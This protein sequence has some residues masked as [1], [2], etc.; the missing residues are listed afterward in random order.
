[1][2][3]AN[4]TDRLPTEILPADRLLT[5]A[6]FQKL[7]DVP[8]EVE[9]FAN[10][11]NRHTRR[12]YENAVKDFMRFAGIF[13]PE[14]FRTVTR[15]HLIAWRDELRRRG[16]GGSTIRHRLAALASLFEYLCERNA[17]T[18]N[19]VKGVERP[20]SE[21]GEGKTPALDDHQARKLLAA[22]EADT[23]K[24]KRDRAI[25]STLLYHALRREELC[26]LTVKDAQHA[27]KGVPHL[28]VSGKGGKT[29]HLPLHGV[30][31]DLIEEYLQ[32]CGHGGNDK[33]ALFR[34]LRNAHGGGREKAI[35]PDGIYKM[36]RLYSAVL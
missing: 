33:G 31:R 2:N 13:R 36:V 5:A 21:S 24:S 1:M 22:P 23:I 9:W 18:Y 7:A 8:P 16:L 29:R 11:S 14:E 3:D 4:T 27:R 32:K 25:L 15:A 10:I 20:K 28:K 17:V 6:E 34:P 30:A 19:P 12:S 26:K 35:T